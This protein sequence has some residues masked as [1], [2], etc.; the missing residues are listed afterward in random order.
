MLTEPLPAPKSHSRC[1]GRGASACSVNARIGALVSWPSCSNSDGQPRAGG[2]TLRAVV[3]I[4][5]Q[6]QRRLQTG[7]SAVL[8]R[9]RARCAAAA[10]PAAAGPRQLTPK[11]SSRS[12]ATA[13]CNAAS[14]RSRHSKRRP[15]PRCGHSVRSGCACSPWAA[16]LLQRPA[17][18]AGGQG[19]RRGRGNGLPLPDAA[20]RAPARC[21]RQTRTDR[22]RPAP[23]PAG[24]AK[25]AAG[26]CQTAPATAF[27]A[28]RLD[29]ASAPDGG[30]ARKTRR[31]CASKR[32][33]DSLQPSKPSSP[34]PMIDSQASAMHVLLLGGTTEARSWRRRWPA[35]A[36]PRRF[37]T[38]A[39]R[40]ADRVAAADPRGRLRRPRGAGGLSAPAAHHARHRR[41][42]PLCRADEPPRH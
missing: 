14:S 16:H 4:E 22:P 35:P 27:G 38:R 7:R 26:R 33:L 29:A 12:S 11:P 17:Q 30:P 40:A 19:E 32:R 1:P 13:A 41:H 15:R 24:R 18:S 6:R 3:Q 20:T 42:A 31:A 39:H 28:L 21:R 2:R 5:R 10:R 25:P 36:Y 9:K 8:D 37:P 34:M 23:P